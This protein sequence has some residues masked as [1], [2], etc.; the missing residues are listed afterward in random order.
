MLTF[1]N[2]KPG[3]EGGSIKG[4]EEKD[5]FKVD[6]V[7]RLT[8]NACVCLI[9]FVFGKKVPK[10]EKQS[11]EMHFLFTEHSVHAVLCVIVKVK[12]IFSKAAVLNWTNLQ[13][14]SVKSHDP[15]TNAIFYV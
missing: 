11:N 4:F 10:K 12:I 6:I 7:R 8:K 2:V 15:N 5:Q 14:S 1:V 9:C 13:P 3:A